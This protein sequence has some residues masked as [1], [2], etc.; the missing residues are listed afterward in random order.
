[1][2]VTW[3]K[4]TEFLNL[5]R[6]GFTKSRGIEVLQLS[7]AGD[8]FIEPVNSKGD[9]TTLRIVASRCPSQPLQGT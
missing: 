4:E 6:N 8:V 7:G 2:R 9:I 5:G 1:M 3:D